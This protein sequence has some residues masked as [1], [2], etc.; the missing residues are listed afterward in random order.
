M[1]YVCLRVMDVLL[2]IAILCTPASFIKKLNIS[3]GQKTSLVGILGH[4]VLY[5]PVPHPTCCSH[6]L[7]RNASCIIA[8]IARLNDTNS[9]ASSNASVF[10]SSIRRIWVRNHPSRKNSSGRLSLAFL[11]VSSECRAMRHQFQ[12]RTTHRLNMWTLK[13]QWGGGALDA[14]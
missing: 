10:D 7:M 2:D 3:K 5:V 12:W 4:G 8:S 9:E 1:I 11:A 14:E 13:S 6:I